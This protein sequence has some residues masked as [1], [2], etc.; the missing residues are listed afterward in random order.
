MLTDNDIMPFGKHKGKPL[1]EVPNGWW[2]TMYRAGKLANDYKT[3]AE[4]TVPI[5]RWEKERQNKK[6][7]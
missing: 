2:E 1:K 5:L 7:T 3:Y 6:S 4:E